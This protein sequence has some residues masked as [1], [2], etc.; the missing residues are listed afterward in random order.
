MKYLRIILLIWP[1]ILFTQGII[2]PDPLTVLSYKLGAPEIFSLYDP[3]TNGITATLV[4]RTG[5]LYEQPGEN[6]F[7]MI[8]RH[9]FWRL[10]TTHYDLSALQ[11][12]LDTIHARV[13]AFSGSGYLGFEVRTDSA[14]LTHALQLLSECSHDMALD[15]ISLDHIRKLCI[16]ELEQRDLDPDHLILEAC[17]DRCFGNDG[18]RIHGRPSPMVLF[19]SGIP[20]FRA[21]L[22]HM[23]SPQS[24]SLWVSGNVPAGDIRQHCTMLPWGIA[25]AR[26]PV[27]PV[28]HIAE[29]DSQ[30]YI[31]YLDGL[32]GASF[33]LCFPMVYPDSLVQTALIAEWC[34]SMMNQPDWDGFADLENRFRV[35]YRRSNFVGSRGNGTLI[36]SFDCPYPDSLTAFATNILAYTAKPDGWLINVKLA[37][38]VRNNMVW[39]Y[40]DQA[41]ATWSYNRVLWKQWALGGYHQVRMH[42]HYMQFLGSTAINDFFLTARTSARPFVVISANPYQKIPLVPIDRINS[43]IVSK[44]T[45]PTPKDFSVQKLPSIPD[46]RFTSGYLLENQAYTAKVLGDIV[47]LLRQHSELRLVITGHS[48]RTGSIQAREMVALGRGNM[49]RDKLVNAGID[50]GRLIVENASDS[51]PVY[52]GEDA[53]GQK[54][55][56]RVSFAWQ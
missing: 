42:L 7:G 3:A 18:Y 45:V 5:A 44:E 11:L 40:L 53:S 30:A 38:V 10:A 50:P 22:E 35:N 43:N 33:H 21:Y 14:H 34:C 56:R 39:D 2:P 19:G 24:M 8:L 28:V 29:P 23:L 17:L 32:Q 20:Q 54:Q 49:I 4:I 52:L 26:K 47:G 25:D 27:T 41:D 16:Q 15:N 12:R 55:N 31:F 1:G 9:A 46:I 48:D 37:E 51:S 6:G 13:S 36:L